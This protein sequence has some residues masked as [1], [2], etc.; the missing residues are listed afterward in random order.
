MSNNIKPTNARKPLTILIVFLAVGVLLV[1]M[2]SVS[3]RFFYF[4]EQVAQ[5]E[6]GVQFESGLSKTSSAP[7][8]IVLPAYLL[9]WKGFPVGRAFRSGGCR[10]DHFRDKQRIGLTVTGDIFRPGLADGEQLRTLGQIQPVIC[11]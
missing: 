9:T 10:V 6:V 2:M 5:D 4:F 7:V 11:Y 1:L 8:S 3:S